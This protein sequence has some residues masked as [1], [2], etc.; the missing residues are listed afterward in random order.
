MVPKP[1]MPVYAPRSIVRHSVEIG[2]KQLGIMEFVD[3]MMEA[4]LNDKINKL[5]ENL[6][7]KFT[8][9]L[10]NN[11]KA[12]DVFGRNSS[13]FLI[14]HETCLFCPELRLRGRGCLLAIDW[15]CCLSLVAFGLCR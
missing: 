12:R 13:P 1:R 8:F 15:L 5:M 11:M 14:G 7:Q 2:L 4:E 3:E 10:R 9:M 6:L